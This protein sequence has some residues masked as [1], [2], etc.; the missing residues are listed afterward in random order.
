[1]PSKDIEIRRVSASEFNL[2]VNTAAG[3]AANGTVHPV[4]SKTDDGNTV[5]VAFYT[6]SGQR[7]PRSYYELLVK[8]EDLALKGLKGD[9][10]ARMKARMAEIRTY[11]SL[12]DTR[13]K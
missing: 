11:L 7:L 9:V 10:Y 1:M 13:K 2:D 5:L 8:N 6:D 4:E 3:L 12:T